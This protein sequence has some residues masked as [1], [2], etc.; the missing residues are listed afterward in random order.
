MKSK[1]IYSFWGIVLILVSGLL[2]ADALD[3]VSLGP[4]TRQFWTTALASA[5]AAFLLTYFVSG[6]KQ[7]GWLFPVTLCAALA[8][9]NAQAGSTFDL[10]H[11]AWPM[12]LAL[13]VPF[14]IGFA[15]D[16]RR[17]GLLLPAY[18]LATTAFI[19]FSGEM[20]DRLGWQAGTHRLIAWSLAAN[21]GQFFLFALPF[22]VLYFWSN[23]NWW[24]LL[25][26]G[27]LA[28][29]GVAL[30]A[31]IVIPNEQQ[32]ALVGAQNAVVLLGFAATLGALWL[33]RATQPTDWAKYPAAGFLILAIG[34]FFLGRGWLDVA[35]DTKA[36]V[37]A[38]GGAVFFI[39]YFLHGVRK[40]GWLFPAGGC[41]ALALMIA[42]ENRGVEGAV[43]AVPILSSLALP[44]FVGFALDRTRRG[45]LIPAS[46]LTLAM[47][48]VL[49]VESAEGDWSGVAALVMLSLPFFA[50]YF[51]SKHG[52]W[53]LIPAGTFASLAACVLVEILIPHQEYPALPNSLSWD[54]YS[55]VLFL[56]LAATFGAVW[57]RHQTEPTNWAKYP[58][59]GLLGLTVLTLLLREHF[60]EVWLATVALV[61]GAT[62]LLA[63]LIERGPG[64]APRSPEARA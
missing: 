61:A 60:Q 23:K 7:W 46:L 19:V 39:V 14:G 12:L 59:A 6:V 40:W 50:A 13:A 11:Q 29:L 4:I 10:G 8:W 1:L 64:A 26:A 63:A 53:A 17:W 25:P 42:L 2:L 56:G 31:Q 37:F 32:N 51:W 5:S 18:L 9:T 35:Q 20:V 62:L 36:L 49:V 24:A 45:L 27:G 38:A 3:Y 44:F 34:T 15:V 28:S 30:L 33:R 57:L 47:V 58:A 48:F 52:W 21:A 22:F 43:M 16:R 54:A 41:T 55:W